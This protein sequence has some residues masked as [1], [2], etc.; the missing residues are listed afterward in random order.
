MALTERNQNKSFLKNFEEHVK[1]KLTISH[2]VNLAKNRY[3]INNRDDIIQA[4]ELGYGYASIAEFATVELLKTGI[5]KNYFYISKDGKEIEKETKIAGAE[6][7]KFY[8]N[9]INCR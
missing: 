2:K 3:L 5:P 1:D 8:E 7:Q 6:V 9:S 4:I